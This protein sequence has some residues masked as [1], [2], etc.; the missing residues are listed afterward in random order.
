MFHQILSTKAYR[1]FK[2]ILIGYI[3]LTKGY[4]DEDHDNANNYN[5]DHPN[6]LDFDCAH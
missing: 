3:Y 2:I 6:A 4:R 1:K 5:F